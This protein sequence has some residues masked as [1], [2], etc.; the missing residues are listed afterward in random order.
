VKQE[1]NELRTTNATSNSNV[2]DHLLQY[3]NH[4]NNDHLNELKVLKLKPLYTDK[5]ID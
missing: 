5:H 2:K 4:L 1:L 3:Y